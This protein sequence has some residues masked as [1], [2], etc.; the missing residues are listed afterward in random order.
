MENNTVRMIELLALKQGATDFL[1]EV[2]VTRTIGQEQSVIEL[3]EYSYQQLLSVYPSNGERV[4]LS[5]YPKWDPFK[6]SHY[7]AIIIMN[8]MS[9]ETLYFTCTEYFME[10]LLQL[11]ESQST[12]P[13]EGE[14]PNEGM[15]P[16]VRTKSRESRGTL[17]DRGNLHLLMRL[18]VI[19]IVFC[20][21]T[22]STNS[23]L[24]ND[25][26]DSLGHS[27]NAASSGND[28]VNAID[29]FE[30]IEDAFDMPSSTESSTIQLAQ[31]EK[32]RD[33]SQ[34]QVAAATVPPEEEKNLS[35][36]A[37]SIEDDKFKYSLPEGY[38]ALSFDD[39]PSAYTEQIVDILTEHEV[40]ATFLFVG[41]NA[42]HDPDAV[43]Y[44][45]EKGMSIGNHSWDHSKL[46]RLDQAAREENLAQTNQMLEQITNK[47]VTIFRPPYGLIDSKLT[48]DVADEDMKVLMWNRD[49]EDWKAKSSKHIL[50][51]F[52]DKDP[53]G[54]IYVLHEKK[55]TVEALPEIITYLKEQELKFVVFE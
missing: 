15:L 3:D 35:Y 10:Q 16:S 20:L 4:R 23:K 53:S 21:F 38:V 2:I 52:H 44:A 14:K 55:M 5:L 33:T 27:V 32:P 1:L 37:I 40:A 11:R 9:S 6:K 8:K 47:P 54:G 48:E 26:A 13:I 19:S 36:E 50:D 43:G 24:F 49:P 39:G 46:S 7:C 25:R 28:S 42:E 12:S 45:S 29:V 41:K 31:Y 34:V 18:A 22:V 51:Y 17:R 30:G